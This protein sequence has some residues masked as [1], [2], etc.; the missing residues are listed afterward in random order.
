MLIPEFI[1][2][3]KNDVNDQDTKR[4]GKENVKKS[5]ELSVEQDRT[6]NYLDQGLL[7]KVYK[8]KKLVDE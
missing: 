2:R 3:W 8:L 1:Q 4:K 7:I 5:G 6:V